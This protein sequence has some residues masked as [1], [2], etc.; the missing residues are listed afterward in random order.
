MISVVDSFTIHLWS[1]MTKVLIVRHS[2]SSCPLFYLI[3]FLKVLLLVLCL[4]DL[5]HL[6]GFFNLLL[7]N[8][9]FTSCAF[10]LV[11]NI[12]FVILNVSFCLGPVLIEFFPVLLFLLLKI[13]QHLL[14][15]WHFLLFDPMH[16]SYKTSFTLG[17]FDSLLCSLF[18]FV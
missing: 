5:V 15:H 6:N 12:Q 4:L 9:N 10:V 11:E 18:F 14:L 2:L 8:F 13:I 1:E 7:L 3:N 16:V 17:I